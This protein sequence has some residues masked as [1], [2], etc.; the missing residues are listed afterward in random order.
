MKVDRLSRPRLRLLL[1]VAIPKVAGASL[2]QKSKK[3][4]DAPFE[5]STMKAV[6]YVTTTKLVESRYTGKAKPEFKVGDCLKIYCGRD[7]GHAFVV[8]GVRFNLGTE[9]FQYLREGIWGAEWLREP[10]V[11]NDHRNRH[12]DSQGYCDNPGR[13]Y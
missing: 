3:I 11:T 13:G 1:L 10:S 5:E 6:R 2:R 9:E 7:E 4:P 12:Y 8:R